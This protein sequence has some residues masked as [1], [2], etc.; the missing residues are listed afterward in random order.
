[1]ENKVDSEHFEALAEALTSKILRRFTNAADLPG[2]SIR[3]AP[4]LKCVRSFPKHSAYHFSPLLPGQYIQHRA[5]TEGSWRLILP[6]V[7]LSHFWISTSATTQ[8]SSVSA[9]RAC[10]DRATGA[11]ENVVLTEDMSDACII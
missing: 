8:S 9:E 2:I 6:N 7:T 11:E 4:I 1:M 3:I 10:D 5:F